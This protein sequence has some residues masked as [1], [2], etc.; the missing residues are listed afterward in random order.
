MKR[1]SG[2][3][4]LGLV[5]TAA[6]VLGLIL[7]LDGAE[8]GAAQQR[9]V[10]MGGNPSRVDS[11]EV[12]LSRLR[13]PAGFRLALPRLEAKPG[14]P[15]AVVQAHRSWLSEPVRPRERVRNG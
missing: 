4:K 6:T 5:V 15:A 10:F 1:E 11:E 9:S 14:R 8:S 2:R 13:F 3:M 12:N 7:V